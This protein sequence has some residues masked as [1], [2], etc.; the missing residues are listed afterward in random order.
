MVEGT[1]EGNTGGWIQKLIETKKW[2]EPMSGKGGK[3]GEEGTDFVKEQ[4]R[5][6]GKQINKW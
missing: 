5:H 2:S 1:G 4:N 3:D 6:I